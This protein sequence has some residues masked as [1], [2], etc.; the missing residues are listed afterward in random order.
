M[1]ETDHKTGTG[2]EFVI[3]GLMAL[4]ASVLA[5]VLGAFKYLYPDVFT[6]IEFYQL[7]PLHVSLALSWIF[8]VSIGGI[9]HYLP[10]YC[11]LALAWPGAVRIHFWLSLATGL[12]IIVSYGLGKFG[13]REYFAYPP[14]FSIAIFAGWLLFG[15]NIFKTLMARKGPWPVYYW[16]WMTGIIFFLITF[17]EAHLWLFP[18][19]N[20]NIVRE[21]AVQ[22]KA[23]GALIGSWN[24]L[25]YGTGIFV[26]E[27]ISGDKKMAHSKQA[28][29]LFLLSFV[30]LMVGWA[31][32]TYAVPMAAWIR[33]LAYIVSMAELYVL[34]KIIW[35]WHSSLTAFQ[36]HRYSQAYRFL[37]AADIWVFL[38]LILAILI[39]IPAF[40]LFSHGTH[41]TVAHAMGATIGINSMILLGSV[42]FLVEETKNRNPHGWIKICV[43]GGYW[44]TN[45]S[46]AVF[47]TA[48][49]L[50][51]VKEGFS[52]WENFYER[53]A[54]VFPLL[55]IFALSGI[56][57][58]LGLWM[59]TAAALRLLLPVCLGM[60][61]ANQATDSPD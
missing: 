11:G 39:S 34:G 19:F 36:K 15:L 38:N 10:K 23:Y 41:I 27:R 43:R 42:F 30:V 25:V 16:M 22:W 13:G 4:G 3:L 52:Q 33:M 6:G 57:I 59:I 24:M 12:G 5:G 18:F 40:N 56:G 48:L 17:S 49:M 7:R 51:G 55:L 21:T 29:A 60:M 50:A 47:L 37:F 20:E 53:S 14:V 44:I 46:L 32:H 61:R 2:L 54:A 8:F 58:L 45:I 31:H 26:M 35:E 28:F 9:Y 1:S